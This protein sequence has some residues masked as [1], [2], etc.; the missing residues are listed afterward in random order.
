M[1]ESKHAKLALS[2]IK[3]K[4][5]YRKRVHVLTDKELEDG[6]NNLTSDTNYKPIPMHKI[7]FINK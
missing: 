5:I 7:N 6:W 3:K 1:D 4:K 2:Q